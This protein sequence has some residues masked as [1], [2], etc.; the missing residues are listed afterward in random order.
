[1]DC[2]SG[3]PHPDFSRVLRAC[4]SQGKQTKKGSSDSCLLLGKRRICSLKTQSQRPGSENCIRL[5]CSFS[6]LLCWSSCAGRWRRKAAAGFHG[7]LQ[8]APVRPLAKEPRSRLSLHSQ[9]RKQGPGGCWMK[10]RKLRGRAWLRG[11]G[12]F[13]V[14]RVSIL[15]TFPL[16]PLGEVSLLIILG[17]S[18][19]WPLADLWTSIP[20]SRGFS[21]LSLLPW[22]LPLDPW[23]Q[24][25]VPPA[26]SSRPRGHPGSLC[27]PCG[28][29]PS[30]PLAVAQHR[31]CSR[32]GNPAVV[33]ALGNSA[34]CRTFLIGN[35]A[36]RLGIRGLQAFCKELDS[37]WLSL[38]WPWGS[39]P[40]PLSSAVGL[41]KQLW[42]I[43]KLMGVNSPQ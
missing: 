33:Q 42:K 12:K 23:R 18:S 32:P 40:Q 25:L 41:W 14:G 15:P 7:R 31:C 16:F 38:S 2:F 34:Q 39:L 30:L 19:R 35:L 9:E 22:P 27:P 21:S 36:P 8:G 6:A 13:S 20:R 26:A 17:P 3:N 24:F 10:Q 4:P 43:H 5:V 1:M 11:A 28:L 29:S 37:K